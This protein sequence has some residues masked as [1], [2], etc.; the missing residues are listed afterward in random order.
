MLEGARLVRVQVEGDDEGPGSIGGGQQRRF[1]DG[2]H[3]GTVAPSLV[4][5]TPMRKPVDEGPTVMVVDDHRILRKGIC[6]LLTRNGISTVAEAGDAAEAVALAAET[7]PDVALVD[8]SL[9]GASGAEAMQR[10]GRV[11]PGTKVLILTMSSSEDDIFGALQAGACG[12][13]LKDSSEEEIAAAIHAAA[14]G[15]APIS[16]RVAAPVLERLR[17]SM[18]VVDLP[19]ESP[20]ELTERELE[21]LGM[22]VDGKDNAKIAATLTISQHTVKNHVSRIFVKLG[23]ENRIQAAVYAVRKRFV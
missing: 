8:L 19:E 17:N 3:G 11:S 12:Y 1:A 7:K 14:D 16:P 15:G 21:V 2:S 20:P 22:I 9:P 5:Q 23:V 18:P 4:Q 10:I 6:A 13:L